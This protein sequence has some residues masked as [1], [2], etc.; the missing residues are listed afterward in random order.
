MLQTLLPSLSSLGSVVAL[1][2]AVLLGGCG[3]KD[4]GP[5][6]PGDVLEAELLDLTTSVLADRRA[7]FLDDEADVD[8]WL[9]FDDVNEPWEELL[10]DKAALL[11][12]IDGLA[13]DERLLSVSWS[14]GGCDVS[15]PTF[16][17]MFADGDEVHVWATVDEELPAWLR[18]PECLLLYGRDFH[19]VVQDVGPSARARWHLKEVSPNLQAPAAPPE[20]NRD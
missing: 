3:T 12:V 7:G 1:C 14:G 4:G 17:G 8:N 19:F 18:G 10:D 16:H 5:P 2:T 20:L 15:Y 9:Q 6:P 13:D 11:D